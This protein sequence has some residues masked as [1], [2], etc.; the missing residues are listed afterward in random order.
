MGL[1]SDSHATPLPWNLLG[2]RLEVL[3]EAVLFLW[4][5][6]ILNH[7]LSKTLCDFYVYKDETSNYTRISDEISIIFTRTSV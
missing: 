3:P 4:S 2:L 6:L 1:R 7:K 5:I